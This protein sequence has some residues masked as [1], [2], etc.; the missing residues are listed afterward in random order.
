MLKDKVLTI[1]AREPFLL[2][3]NAVNL[4]V[5]T[6]TQLGT[7]FKTLS[8]QGDRRV[9]RPLPLPPQ[10]SALLMSYDHHARYLIVRAGSGNQ[11]RV[12]G[13]EIPCTIIVLYPRNRP[14]VI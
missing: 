8:L 11:T 4:G 13:L 10:G 12:I 6:P 5:C 1:T 3:Q 14:I 2:I 7:N 9:L